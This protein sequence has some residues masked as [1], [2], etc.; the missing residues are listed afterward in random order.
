MRVGGGGGGG[1]KECT[2]LRWGRVKGGRGG[3]GWGRIG[4]RGGYMVRE[5][6]ELMEFAGIVK[7]CR[8]ELFLAHSEP[9]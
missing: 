3:W 6:L 9:R 2:A 4:V 1:R 5:V 8:F 7:D